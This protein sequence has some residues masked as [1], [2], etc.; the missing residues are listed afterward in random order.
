MKN[1]DLVLMNWYQD[2]YSGDDKDLM[3]LVGMLIR[4][5]END[6]YL[7]VY[8]NGN[9]YGI[10]T[11][12]NVAPI[13]DVEYHIIRLSCYYDDKINAYKSKIKHVSKEDKDKEK[14]EKFENAKQRLLENCRRLLTCVDDEDILNRAKEINNLKGQMQNIEFECAGEIRKA[15]GTIKHSIMELNSK[16]AQALNKLSDEV[17]Y[18]NFGR[19]IESK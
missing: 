14:S 3:L 11:T 13:E 18:R 12:K 10:T 8:Y 19:L 4:V 1:G 5:L 7:V 6:T 17:I 16:K 9:S 15:N 2:D